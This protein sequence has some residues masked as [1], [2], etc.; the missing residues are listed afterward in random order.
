MTSFVPAP[1]PSDFHSSAA[2]GAVVGAEEEPA[3]EGRQILGVGVA[4]GVDVLDQGG[5]R[6]GAVGLPEL[7]AVRGVDGGEEERAGIVREVGEAVERAP[8]SGV[9][10]RDTLGP[11]RRA[12]GLPQLPAV[13]AVVGNEEEFPGERRETRPE[14]EGGLRT[15]PDVVHQLGARRG[16]VGLPELGAVR[17]VGRTEEER[18]VD[19]RM[20]PLAA[21]TRGAWV[22]VLDHPRPGRGA[23][24]LPELVAVDAVVGPEERAA[25]QLPE[26]GGVRVRAPR[27]DVLDQGRR[28][29]L[30][31]PRDDE[32]GGRLQAVSKT[33]FRNLRRIPVS[34]AS[35]P[36]SP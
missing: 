5:P 23:V 9:D 34:A 7:D 10:V 31:R 4:G 25:P 3:A 19:G 29:G 15:R 17:R 12:V 14:R 24:G 6:H 28:R 11:G 13:G 16:A 1:V 21:G 27:V 18:A 22:D 2:V 32:N 30:R 36:R 33:Q 8:T 20:L 35:W 26:R